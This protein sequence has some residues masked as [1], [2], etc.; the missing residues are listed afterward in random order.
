MTEA[1]LETP[2]PAALTSLSLTRCPA[3]PTASA[4][5]YQLG[6]LQ[7]E[8][9]DEPGLD[10]QFKSIGFTG[11]LDYAHHERL[12]VRN[13]GHA[14]AVWAK[15]N[16][17]DNKVVAL[18]WLKGSYPLLSLRGSG[19]D[20]PAELKGKRLAL[21]GNHEASFDLLIAQQLK[22]YSATL[23]TVGLTLDDV[24]LVRISKPSI[25]AAAAGA[26]K[27]DHFVELARVLVARLILGD[28]E[29]ISARLPAEVAAF[30]DVQTLYDLHEHS[31]PRA[32]VHPSVLRGL[33]VSRA[34]LEERRD[35]VVRYLA[36]LLQATE[37]AAAHPEEAAELVAQDLGVPVGN[38]LASYDSVSD[39][40]QLRLD[41]DIVDSL[42]V[43]KDFL[44][45]HG[46]IDKDFDFASWVDQTP[47]QEARHLLAQWKAAGKLA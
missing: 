25:P 4:L 41:D 14:P 27:K 26:P 20:S 19:I 28:V 35:I 36:R 11:K 13:A 15:S 30:A 6:Y 2:A 37:W 39:G 46:F 3:V 40:L 32:R 23:A 9:A 21:I 44:L 47:L 10:T 34:L 29:V 33:V 1:T 45:A 17:V 24:E 42:R 12:W 8:F 38:L 16:G 31:D 18:A 7:E 5:A 22:I 43:Q